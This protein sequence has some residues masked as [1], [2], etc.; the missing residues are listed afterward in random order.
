MRKGI[1]KFLSCPNNENGDFIVFAHE[2]KRANKFLSNVEHEDINDNDDIKTGFI[3]TKKHLNVYPITNYILSALSDKDIDQNFFISLLDSALEYSPLRYKS[4]IQANI[5]RIKKFN[6]KISVDW[7]RDEMQYYDRAVETKVQRKAFCEKVKKEP[8]WNIY[9][10]R[11][12]YLFNDLSLPDSSYVL[13]IGC[14]NART[15]DWLYPPRKYNYNYVGTDISFK[16][17]MLAKMV[18]PEGDFIQ[19]SALNLPFKNQ[20]FA[21]ILSFGVLHHLEN[22][23]QGALS[24]L[25]KL[26]NEGYFLIHEPIKKPKKLLP[27]GKFEFLQRI[28]KTYDHSEHDNHIHVENTLKLFEEQNNIIQEV[29]FNASVLRTVVYRIFTAFPKISRSERAW[30]FFIEADKVFIRLFCSTPNR[31]GPGGVFIRLK[32]GLPHLDI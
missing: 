3:V 28:F 10:E 6:P 27:E 29:H 21:A 15:V 14:G 12:N 19:C 32:K 26:R 4:T 17:L 1:L 25:S 11:N 22:P 16:R 13:E 20:T 5:E 24:C 7:N 18:I 23:M 8:L 31:F 9:I 2:L 30:K